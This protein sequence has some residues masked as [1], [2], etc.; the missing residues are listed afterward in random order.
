[1]VAEIDV[2]GFLAII[3]FYLADFQ[4]GEEIQDGRF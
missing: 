2:F 1:M 4:D 3:Q